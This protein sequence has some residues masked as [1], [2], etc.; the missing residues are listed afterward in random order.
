MVCSGSNAPLDRISIL[1]EKTEIINS[2]IN[3]D[4]LLND[5]YVNTIESTKSEMIKRISNGPIESYN[6]KPK[7]L[8]RNSRGLKNIEYCAFCGCSNLK[9]RFS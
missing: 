8:K 9:L 5:N 3:P 6:R 2:L 4:T 7:D 1:F